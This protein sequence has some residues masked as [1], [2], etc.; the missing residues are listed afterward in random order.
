MTPRVGFSARFFPWY[1]H[2]SDITNAATPSSTFCEDLTMTAVFAA[3]SPTRVP[4]AATAPVVSIVPPS[5]APATSSLSPMRPESHGSR[6]IIGI[7]MISTR[8]MT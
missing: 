3:V 2:M 5:H 6:Y 4:E 1:D 8:E 7:A